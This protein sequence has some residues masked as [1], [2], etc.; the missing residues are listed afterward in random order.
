MDEL[1]TLLRQ[2]QPRRPRPLPE[3]A[4]PRGPRWSVW[5]AVPGIAAVVIIVALVARH[6]PAPAVESPHVVITL[7]ALNARVLASDEDLDAVL[8]RASRAIL[9]DVERPGGVLQALSKE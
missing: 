7:G 3:I 6:D 9:P 8:T 1:E 4:R 2:F 5:I